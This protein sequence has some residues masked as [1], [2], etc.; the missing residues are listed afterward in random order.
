MGDLISEPTVTSF[1]DVRK[2]VEDFLKSRRPSTRRQYYADLVDLELIE[3]FRQ[4]WQT[5]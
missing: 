5:A 2:G 4:T 3:E 1:A